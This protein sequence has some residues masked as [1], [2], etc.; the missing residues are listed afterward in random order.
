MEPS[1]LSWQGLYDRRRRCG[2]DVCLVSCQA[3]HN[4]RKTMQEVTSKTDEKDADSV[5]DLLRQ[6]KFFLPVERDA[7]LQAAARLM[8]RHMAWKKRVSH[9]RNQLRAAI[10]LTV[11]Q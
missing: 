10:L 9:L 8:P 4:N 6:G 11:P 7:A 2:Y 5:L 1:G 3:V